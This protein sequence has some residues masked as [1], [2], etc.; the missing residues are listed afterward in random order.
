[1]AYESSSNNFHLFI[2]TS[3]TA[4][5][6]YVEL[7]P[8]NI[9]FDSGETLD[10]WNDLSNAFANNVKV[11]LD[12]TWSLSFKFDKASAV[13]QF[14][15]GKEFLTGSAATCKIRITNQLK[16]SFGKQIDFTGTIS[17]ITYSALTEEVL[18]V[19]FDIKVASNLTFVETL[20]TAS[21]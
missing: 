14:I 5:P 6:S 11:A 17:G 8:L 18:N 1:M 13:A 3:A 20:N 7:V 21:I 19:S 12:P 15:L 16:G 4:T 9:D 2:D 10:T